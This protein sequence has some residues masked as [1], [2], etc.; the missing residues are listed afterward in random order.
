MNISTI[1]DHAVSL[2][3]QGHVMNPTHARGILTQ[4]EWSVGVNQPN[5]ATRGLDAI[6]ELATSLRD[7]GQEIDQPNA[8]GIMQQIE[9]VINN[10]VQAPV[11]RRVVTPETPMTT[12]FKSIDAAQFDQ[13]C[14][15]PVCM[16][17][18]N[19]GESTVTDCGH[20]FCNPCW[21]QWID[22]S[23]RKTCP[24][25][26]KSRPNTTRFVVNAPSEKI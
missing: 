11:R 2:R 9:W 7:Q 1:I 16:E 24:T 19:F 17:T 10:R 14:E 15:C 20:T 4:I 13:P 23:S 6:I 5:R 21:N 8:R 26:R 22:R 18:H 25:C 3:E 12:H